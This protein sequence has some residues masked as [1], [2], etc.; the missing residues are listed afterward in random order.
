MHPLLK[1]KGESNISEQVQH[2]TFKQKEQSLI[3]SSPTFFTN[4]SSSSGVK[5]RSQHGQT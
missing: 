5:A 2:L 4:S 3:I 1:W